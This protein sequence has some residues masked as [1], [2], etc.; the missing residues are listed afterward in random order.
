MCDFGYIL[1]VLGSDPMGLW[2][3]ISVSFVCEMYNI[4]FLLLMEC[5]TSALVLL[6]M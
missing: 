5:V 6:I 1:V 3:V 2:I 4:R